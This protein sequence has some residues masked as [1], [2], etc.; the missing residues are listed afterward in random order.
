[1]IFA[2]DNDIFVSAASAWEIA[3]KIRKGEQGKKGGLPPEAVVALDHER[4]W[5]EHG[6]ESLPLRFAHGRLAGALPFAHKDPFDRMP[7]AQAML[8]GMVLVSNDGEIR[9]FEDDRLQLL[10]EVEG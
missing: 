6:F 9:T 1:M 3:T 7:I 4:M 10:W 2:S 5:V 8:E